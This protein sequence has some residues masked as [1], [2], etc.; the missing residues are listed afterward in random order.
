MPETEAS[1]APATA[2]GYAPPGITGGLPRKR[3][4]VKAKAKAEAEAE[5]D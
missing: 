3:R 2:M 5:E 4:R 1:T